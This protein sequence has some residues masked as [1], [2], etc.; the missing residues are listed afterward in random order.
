MQGQPL[1]CFVEE[2]SRRLRWFEH[3]CD[4]D[5]ANERT[6]SCERGRRLHR[7][8]WLPLFCVILLCAAQVG[9]SFFVTPTSTSG[10]STTPASSVEVQSNPTP[11][12]VSANGAVAPR[13]P[14]VPRPTSTP[15]PAGM[16]D[17]TGGLPPPVTGLPPFPSG[18]PPPPSPPVPGPAAGSTTPLSLTGLGSAT[19]TSSINLIGV[20]SQGTAATAR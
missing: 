3:V 15:I 14:E 10:S 11:W 6:A 7:H 5:S 18:A 2:N 1:A 19:T 20:S 8:E 16:N 9:C 13:V 4:R 12:P 17:P